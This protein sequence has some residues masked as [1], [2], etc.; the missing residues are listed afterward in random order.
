MD[1]KRA[2]RISLQRLHN[3][4]LEFLFFTSESRTFDN[5]RSFLTGAPPPSFCKRALFFARICPMEAHGFRR[6]HGPPV[7]NKS[8]NTE[9]PRTREFHVCRWN[10]IS[11]AFVMKHDRA[12]SLPFYRPRVSFRFLQTR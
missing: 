5:R 6:R 3:K 9:V 2:R 12:F 4:I 10:L 7:A 1:A 8:R 11:A